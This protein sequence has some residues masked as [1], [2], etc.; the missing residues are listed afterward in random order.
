ML[1]AFTAATAAVQLSIDW[2]PVKCKTLT[3]GIRGRFRLPEN[4]PQR[5]KQMKILILPEYPGEY[6]P[7][8]D[9]SLSYLELVDR[10]TK[11]KPKSAAFRKTAPKGPFLWLT[12][13]GDLIE[14]AD[15]ATQHLYYAIRMLFNHTVPA[16]YRT[17]ESVQEIKK[18]TDVPKWSKAY[19]TAASKAL[20]AELRTRSTGEL[21]PSMRDGLRWMKMVNELLAK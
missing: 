11:L 8:L 16:K 15:M 13:S 10:I 7:Q 9:A 17:P 2:S 19:K 6:I 5:K 14:P 21:T 12:H 18:Y 3:V 1:G 4:P 20:S